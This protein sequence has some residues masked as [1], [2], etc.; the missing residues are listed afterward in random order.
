MQMNPDNAAR[1]KDVA[2]FLADDL[3]KLAPPK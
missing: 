3:K 2:A 1:F